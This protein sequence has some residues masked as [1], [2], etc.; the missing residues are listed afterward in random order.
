MSELPAENIAAD[1]VRDTNPLLAELATMVRVE[2]VDGGYHAT[3]K[4]EPTLSVLK[5]HFAQQ[6]ILPGVCMVQVA[7]LAAARV[8]GRPALRLVTIKNAKMVHPILPGDVVDFYGQIQ[9]MEQ[10]ANDKSEQSDAAESA[11]SSERWQIRTRLTM[12]EKRVA[13]LSL[14]AR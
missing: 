14:I 2:V 6:P 10:P 11:A 7:L 13:E 8:L 12:A 9:L 3:L 5:D 4:V 1:A